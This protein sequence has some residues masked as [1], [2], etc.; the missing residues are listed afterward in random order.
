MEILCCQ[1]GLRVRLLARALFIHEV[2]LEPRWAQVDIS[3][4]PISA[5]QTYEVLLSKT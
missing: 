2:F 4:I 3:G 1:H 5:F